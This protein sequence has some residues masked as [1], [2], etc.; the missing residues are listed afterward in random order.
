MRINLYSV[1]DVADHFSRVKA[2]FTDILS[3]ITLF[4]LVRFLYR[5]A[6]AFL[7]LTP[8]DD[9]WD[10]ANAENAAKFTQRRKSRS[11][12]ILLFISVVIGGPYLIWKLL[13]GAQNSAPKPK[14]KWANGEADHVVARAEY[15]F[16]SENDDELS[17]R[18]G[19]VLHLAPKEQ[20]S[21]IRDW[22]LASVDGEKVG[23]VPANYVKILG[24]RKGRSVEDNISNLA[25][26]GSQVQL[27][28]D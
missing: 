12:P 3:S 24:K 13:S 5:R 18:V 6:R 14:M 16:E 10:T 27:T 11:W 4:R 22:L 25:D 26:Q 20:Q 7:N 23:M 9:A 28:T 21:S 19:D 15:S 2:T 17:F 8:C 1:S